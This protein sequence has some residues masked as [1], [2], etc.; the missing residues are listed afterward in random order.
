MWM[1][2]NGS[3]DRG[4][5]ATTEFPKT[6]GKARLVALVARVA[7]E[8]KIYMSDPAD[9][10]SVWRKSLGGSLPATLATTDGYSYA[11]YVSEVLSDD[12]V[13]ADPTTPFRDPEP[14]VTGSDPP[15]DSPLSPDPI[16]A[17]PVRFVSSDRGAF[18]VTELV[19]PTDWSPGSNP[20]SA[21]GVLSLLSAAGVVATVEGVEL[22]LPPETPDDLLDWLAV[23]HTG[24]RAVLRGCRW[25][26][27]DPRPGRTRVVELDPAKPIPL[28]VTLLCVEADPGWDRIHHLAVRDF[29][30]LFG[31]PLP[32]P[33]SLFSQLRKKKGKRDAKSFRNH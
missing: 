18:A 28:G 31:H 7:R 3:G 12:G 15:P 25:I 27:S 26:G 30:D 24:V 10:G 13:E 22:A 1:G 21:V 19:I 20:L 9:S 33:K 17:G 4:R 16:P 14:R 29:P 32:R 11:D 8:E 23:I 6:K 2:S 5:P